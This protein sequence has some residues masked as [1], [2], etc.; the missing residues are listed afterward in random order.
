MC[1]Q[2]LALFFVDLR[3]PNTKLLSR[4]PAVSDVS[5][6]SYLLSSAASEID[7]V[8][9]L[10]LSWHCM[11][12]LRLCVAIE[13]LCVNQVANAGYPGRTNSS[14]QHHAPI[15]ST[16]PFV[17]FDLFGTILAKAKDS[18]FYI[19]LVKSYSTCFTYSCKSE[20]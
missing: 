19:M 20:S 14:A 15:H 9:L 13:V 2:T 6:C 1:P 18:K 7:E 12:L 4:A 16:E 8:L 3:P 5:F 11:T 17:L 10:V